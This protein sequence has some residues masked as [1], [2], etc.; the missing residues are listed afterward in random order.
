MKLPL[1]TK[2][3]KDSNC[4]SN[5][6]NNKR[7]LTLT[8]DVEAS[9]ITSTLISKWGSLYLP[10]PNR[11]S[12]KIAD[13]YDF[14]IFSPVLISRRVSPLT[15]RDVGGMILFFEDDA[16]KDLSRPRREEVCINFSILVKFKGLDAASFWILDLWKNEVLK[17]VDVVAINGCWMIITVPEV[18]G[19]TWKKTLQHVVF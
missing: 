19:M 13:D 14:C 18:V 3:K 5:F 9:S 11:P 17:L 2:S 4:T 15:Q 6:S 1:T 16:E 10:A 8:C 12:H 7:L